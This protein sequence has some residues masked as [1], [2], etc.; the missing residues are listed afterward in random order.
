[1]LVKLKDGI[2]AVLIALVLL[3]LSGCITKPKVAEVPEPPVISVPNRPSIPLNTAPDVVVKTTMDYILQLEA[4][5]KKAV[6]AL[7]IYRKDTK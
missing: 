1:M 7:D 5:L 2:L 4:A 6:S 3:L